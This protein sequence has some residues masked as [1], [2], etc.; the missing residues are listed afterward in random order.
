MWV[1]VISLRDPIRILL[2]ND[3]LASLESAARFLAG[4]PQVEIV[5][6]ARSGEEALRQ[7][8]ELQPDL[9]LMDL[10]MHGMNGLE[11]TRRIKELPEAP[12]VIIVTLHDNS[13]YRAA[14]QAAQADGFIFKADFADQILPLIHTLFGISNPNLRLSV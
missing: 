6:L 12:R 2:T 8:L 13:G 5:G 14:A 7:V 1:S 9:V 10:E 11:A 4:D 3:S